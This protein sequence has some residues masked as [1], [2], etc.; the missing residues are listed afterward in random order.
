MTAGDHWAF[1]LTANR[2]HTVHRKEGEPRKL[3]AHL[4]PVHQMGWLLDSDA[5]TPRLPH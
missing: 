5:R 1:R 2:V 4:T 3:T